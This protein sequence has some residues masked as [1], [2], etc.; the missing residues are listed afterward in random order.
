LLISK[1]NILKFSQLFFN[2]EKMEVEIQM[3]IMMKM[4]STMIK[5]IKMIQIIKEGLNQ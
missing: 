3:I 1:K 2:L 4:I 5:E